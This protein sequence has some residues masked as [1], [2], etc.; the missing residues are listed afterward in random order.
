[1]TFIIRVSLNDR[2]QLSG[3][4]ERVRTGEKHRF[5]TADAISRIIKR[6]VEA[7]KQRGSGQ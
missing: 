6:L 7:E 3:I 4:V 5:D 1:M 2:D